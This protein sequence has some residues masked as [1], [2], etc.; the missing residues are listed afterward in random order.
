VRVNPFRT[1][2]ILVDPVIF[3]E[4]SISIFIKYY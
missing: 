2:V 4:D 1:L 3:F